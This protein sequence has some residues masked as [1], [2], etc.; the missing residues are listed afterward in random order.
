MSKKLL[1]VL[2]VLVVAAGFTM[3]QSTR[4][5]NGETLRILTANVE[6]DDKDYNSYAK[7]PSDFPVLQ[8]IE[9]LTGLKLQIEAVNSNDY[10]SVLLPR[11]AAKTNLPDVFVQGGGF[12]IVKYATDGV[13][14]SIGDVI[15]K[16]APETIA[17]WKKYPDIQHDT[18][19]PDGN[20]YGY[21]GRIGLADNKFNILAMGYRSDWA[22]KLGIKDPD[23]IGDWYAMLKA[24]LT[25]DPNGN[26][27]A[28][29][30]PYQ[31]GDNGLYCFAN[32]YGMSPWNDWWSVTKAGKV[33][34]DWSAAESQAKAKAW[35]TE[36][37]KWFKEKLVDQEYLVDHGDKMDAMTLTNLGG[38]RLAWSAAF[39]DWNSQMKKDYPGTKWIVA[40]PP[41]GPSGDRGSEQYGIVNNE[42]WMVTTA[43]KNPVLAVKWMNF[44]FAT[45]QGTDLMNWGVEGLSYT[46]K[47]GKKAFTD[48]A[49]NSRYGAGGAG[50]FVTSL[51]ASRWP[52]QLP[53]E[54][55]A[56]M[57]TT[58]T[59]EYLARLATV[60]KNGW[61]RRG[62]YFGSIPATPAE[63]SA[64]NVLLSD[65]RTTTSEWFQKFI[66]GQ[67]PLSNYDKFVAQLKKLGIDEITAIKQKQ[68]TRFIGT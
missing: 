67:E 68:Y 56:A 55:L 31:S 17:L 11:I 42:R 35:L 43:A 12:D 32:A 61:F 26:G 62:F 2:L 25:K 23:T 5:A 50:T 38:A 16:N 15:Q 30:V 63:S 39:D 45:P 41:K 8:K 53:E 60:D 10:G 27:K 44:M 46:V 65:V 64:L 49:L 18:T 47:G 6:V 1:L 33:L 3:A 9:E 58:L 54:A 29:E 40:Y 21:P 20:V 52:H 48:A 4:F 36:M 51:G 59:P 7:N 66:V 22:T 24:F 37:N 13:I 28:D 14:I 19:A 34:Y 57:F